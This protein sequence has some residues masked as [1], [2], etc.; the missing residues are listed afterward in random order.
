MVHT[1]ALLTD[2]QSYCPDGAILV[3]NV[4]KDKQLLIHDA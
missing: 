3:Q 1:Q 2:E 4:P